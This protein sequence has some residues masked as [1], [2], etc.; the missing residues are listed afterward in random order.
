MAQMELDKTLLYFLSG[1]NGVG[2]GANFDVLP[3]WHTWLE[4]G[5]MELELE[6]TV[7]YFLCGIRG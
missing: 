2:I 5:I 6:Q 7:L 1:D 4:V 3:V